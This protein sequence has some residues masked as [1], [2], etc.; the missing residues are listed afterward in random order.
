MQKTAKSNGETA[1]VV[2]PL[3][4]IYS[5]KSHTLILGTMPSPA[6]RAA[7]FYYAHPQNR[8]WPVLAA[9]YGAPIPAD[10]AARTAL[11]LQNGLALW[12]V[13]KQCEI[14]GAS[15]A[16]IHNPVPNDIAALLLHAPITRII[17]TGA[18]AAR[19]YR[20]WIAPVTGMPC[21]ALPSTSAANAGMSLKQ[22]T[23]VYAKALLFKEDGVIAPAISVR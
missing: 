4:P 8:F 7:Q 15:D 9:I 13:L 17:T 10:N 11:I 1:T 6:S 23:E 16:S 3:D 21:I 22:L 5:V 12:D 18:A 19:L 2:H 20:K 14:I